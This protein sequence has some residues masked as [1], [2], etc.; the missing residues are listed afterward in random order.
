[1]W[2]GWGP[3]AEYGGEDGDVTECGEAYEEEALHLVNG[4]FSQFD[5]GQD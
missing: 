5:I 3:G 4:C 1:M 2:V